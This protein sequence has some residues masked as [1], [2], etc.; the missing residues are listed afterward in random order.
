MADPREELHDAMGAIQVA[1]VLLELHAGLMR[2]FL[3]ETRDLDNFGHILN[4]TLWKDSE[5][6][7]VSAL[8]EP[9]FRAALTFTEAVSAQRAAALAAL[10]KVGA[11]G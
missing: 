8:V 9:L 4:P 5:R 2:R 11:D 7:A 3:K 1:S 10:A 6:R